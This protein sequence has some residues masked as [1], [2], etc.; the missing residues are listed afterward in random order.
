MRALDLGVRLLYDERERVAGRFPLLY[1]RVDGRPLPEPLDPLELRL[2]LEP[3][4]F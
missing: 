2:P 3:Y 1:D 4:D